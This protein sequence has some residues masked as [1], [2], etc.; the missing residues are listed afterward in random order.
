M[1][2][3]LPFWTQ[4]LQFTGVRDG[5]DLSIDPTTGALVYRGQPKDFVNF[6]LLLFRDTAATRE[7]AK[8]LKDSFVAEGIGLAAAAAISIFSSLPPGITVPATRDLAKKA[9]NT[10]LDYFAKRKEK[11]IGT[12]YASLIRETDYGLGLHPA[13]FPVKLIHCGGAM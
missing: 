6:H 1:R 13:E 5:A 11:L 9:V 12:F 7:F 4:Q 8:V 3:G 10:T 2:S